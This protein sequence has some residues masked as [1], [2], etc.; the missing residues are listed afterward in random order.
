[1]WN[2]IQELEN[3]DVRIRDV[4]SPVSKKLIMIL[5]NVCEVEEAFPQ[6]LLD[7]KVSEEWV[8]TVHSRTSSGLST[9]GRL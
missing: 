3:L 6:L 2:F 4:R 8:D 5:S 1:M 9:L 7:W